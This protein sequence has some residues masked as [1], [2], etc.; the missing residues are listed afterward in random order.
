MSSDGT[1]LDTNQFV[2]GN[3]SAHLARH[4]NRVEQ[5][6]KIYDNFKPPKHTAFHW[7][8]KFCKKVL[9]QEFGQGHI[10][11]VVSGTDYEEGILVGMS[12]LPN[13]EGLTVAK[14]CYDAMVKCKCKD[15]IRVLVWDTTNSNSGIHKGADA[16]LER[17]L[18]GRKLVW[19]ACRKHVAELLVK[20]VYKCV[21]GEAKSSDYGDFKDFQRVLLKRATKNDKVVLDAVF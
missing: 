13:G 8:E 3:D 9:G 12:A 10:V 19:G 17:D 21:F 4:K 2:L 7:D 16:I 1:P 20:P 14:V 6:R 5:D 18:L 11:M 15:N